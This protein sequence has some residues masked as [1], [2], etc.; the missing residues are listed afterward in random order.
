RQQHVRVQQKYI[1]APRGF[2]R[3]IVAP[4]V[5]RIVAVGDE[6]NLRKARRDRLRAA[7]GGSVVHDDD[8]ERERGRGAIDAGERVQQ[9][10]AGVPVDDGDRE[11]WRGVGHSGFRPSSLRPPLQGTAGLLIPLR[12][13]IPR[14]RR[15]PGFSKLYPETR[16]ERTRRLSKVL[17]D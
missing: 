13:A 6:M 17:P 11:R 12:L 4:R 7:V 14:N 3:L 10:V 5:A 9:Q 15:L 2:Y 8:L 1:R 16:Q